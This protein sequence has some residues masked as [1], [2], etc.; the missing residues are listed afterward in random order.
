M[1]PRPNIARWKEFA[2]WSS[3]DQIEQDLI[4]SRTHVEI[5][6]DPFLNENLAFRGGTALHKLYLNPAPRYS[7]DI[8]LVQIKPGPIKPIMEKI[9]EV[10]T[11]FEEPRKTDIRGHGP[12][13]YYRFNSEYEGIRMRLKIEINSKEHFNVLDWVNFPFHIENEWFTG[14]ASIKTYNINELLGTKLRALYQRTKGRDLFDLYYSRLNQ[15]IEIDQIIESFNEYMKF[16]TGNIPTRRQFELNI[17]EKENDPNFTGDMEA[18]L[19]PGIKYDQQSAFEW[20]KN[21]VISKL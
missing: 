6:S 1:I 10:I 19:R 17:E 14:S 9:N 8:D 7:E 16:S 20:L 12:K 4:I 18:I 15:K 5:F 11:F 13:M 21:D 3:F 2:P